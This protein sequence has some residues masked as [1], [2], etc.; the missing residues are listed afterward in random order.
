MKEASSVVPGLAGILVG[1]WKDS[2]TYVRNKNKACASVGINSFEKCPC[3]YRH[4]NEQN[5]L[6]AVN[7]EKDV[8]GFLPH[9]QI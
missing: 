3:L 8:D 6:N 2:A 9:W 7:T 1:D 4:I 5:V